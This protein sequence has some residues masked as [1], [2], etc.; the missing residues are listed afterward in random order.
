MERRWRLGRLI[1]N[2][3]RDRGWGGRTE[4]VGGRRGGKRMGSDKELD[5][6]KDGKRM[7]RRIK[8]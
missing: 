6:E 8:N 7:G 2:W 5:G 1:K 4:L 3:W